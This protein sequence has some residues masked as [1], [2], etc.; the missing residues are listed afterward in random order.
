MQ[1][2]SAIGIMT[3]KPIAT[4]NAGPLKMPSQSGMFVS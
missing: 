1:K 2:M 4:T 3:T